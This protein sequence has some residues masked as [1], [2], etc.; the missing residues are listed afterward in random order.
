MT[1]AAHISHSLERSSWIRQM[2]ETGT[3]LKQ[4]HGTD[5]VFD[6]SLGNP[7]LEPPPEVHQ[8]LHQL[9]DDSSPG[10]H[11]YMPNGGF[12]H[13]REF[14]ADE[15]KREHAGM[16][17]TREDVV[18]CVGAGG[19]LNVVLKALLNPGD[20]VIA[21]APYFVEYDFYVQ[22]HGGVLKVSS[23]TPESF[24]PDLQALEATITEKTRALLVNS[25]NNPTGVVYSQP[26]LDALGQWLQKQEQRFGHPIYL[27]AD[28]P[29]R[30]LLFDGVANGSVFSAHPNSI[31][32]TSHSKDLGLAGERIGYIALH[33]DIAARTAWQQALVFT[34]RVLGFVNAPALMQRVLPHLRGVQVDVQ[35]YARLRDLACEMLRELGFEF[36]RPQG[37][38][39]LFPKALEADDVAFVRR[40]QAE[41]IL[42]VPGSG[43]GG[44]GH[45]RLS[46]CCPS[47][48]LERSYDA[49]ARLARHYS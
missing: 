36:V 38:F 31:L 23:T 43:F 16:P 41:R 42:L 5:N 17:F 40:A 20:E 47:E 9:L 22:N 15:M 33:P 45:F 39:Y 48:V 49:F 2:F 19:G 18:C 44:A 27:L 13:V 34:N 30:K 35:Q 10:Q 46:Y 25:P 6:F 37:A 28:E 29:Y 11:R 3:R 1:I 21:L 32:V 14:L 26:V 12:P 7:M 4:E 24:L 8:A